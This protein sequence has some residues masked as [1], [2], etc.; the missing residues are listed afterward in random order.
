MSTAVKDS[1]LAMDVSLTSEAEIADSRSLQEAVVVGY[2]LSLASRGYAQR[3]NCNSKVCGENFE[4][5][6]IPSREEVDTSSGWLFPQTH[7]PS[8]DSFI[9]ITLSLAPMMFL[10]GRHD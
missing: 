3:K 5:H 7:G 1:R 8:G 10:L 6:S 9:L 2:S 4:F